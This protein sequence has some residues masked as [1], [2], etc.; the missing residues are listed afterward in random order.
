MKKM[1]S[2]ISV[3]VMGLALIG[4]S[5]KTIHEEEQPNLKPMVMVDGKIYLDTGKESTV[6]SRCG[7]M[8][9]KIASTVDEKS[10][11]TKDNQSNFGTGYDYQYGQKKG[12]IE[13]H[14]DDQWIVYEEEN[15][16]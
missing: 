8:D 2:L 15:I 4:C 9:G 3:L 7:V 11:P 10:K 14:I 13:V 12:T 6:E 1:M 16:K 5:N